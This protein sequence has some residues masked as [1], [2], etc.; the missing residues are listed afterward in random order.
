[1]EIDRIITYA[2]E[3]K[4]S[5]LDELISFLQIPSVSTQSENKKDIENA[6][7]WL[8]GYLKKINANNIKI[9]PTS[10]HPVV[11]ADYLQ[12]SAQA[13]TVLIYGHYDVQPAD[14]IE[15]WQT[16]PFVPTIRNNSLFARGASDMK[17]QIAAC[18]FA[19]ES[20]LSQTP[21]PVNVK[22]IFEGEEEIGSPNLAPFIED[23]KDL[24]SSTFAL[25]PDTGMI[26][27]DVPTIVYGLR[28]LA[29]FE[30]RI[31]GPA[32]DLHSGV[33]GGIIH[34]PA[35][36]LCEIIAGMHDGE[37]RINLPGFYDKV[38]PISKDE[39]AEL[40]K[41]PMNDQY[42]LEQTGSP[43]IWNEKG[44]SSTESAGAR[45]TMDVHGLLSGFTGEG[46]KTVI[47]SLALAKLSFRLV[48]DQDPEEVQQQLILYLEKNAPPSIRWELIP[49]GHGPACISD[50]KHPAVIA[51]AKAMKKVWGKDP[52]F[53]REGGSVPIVSDMQ[54]LLN[55]GSVL[56]GFGLPDDNIHAPNEKLDLPT[57]GN[58]IDTLIHFF[59]NISDE[60]T[61]S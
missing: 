5:F 18:L 8:V 45:P 51:L 12:A 33:F 59:F 11:Y 40:A 22:F 54:N 21:L 27:A 2:H 3:H 35:T 41:L 37:K 48:P 13:P 19:I 46:S 15:L 61:E 52:V 43:L 16:S 50:R 10:G 32:H 42:Y 17:G 36:A 6:A 26:A 57:W 14:P 34:N 24:L 20:I 31:F 23:H 47:P 58:G 28:G 1:M 39:K 44:Y 49:M 55:I 9:L 29:Y 38:R 30:L 53:K 4:K 7:K 25:N 60:K 56:T